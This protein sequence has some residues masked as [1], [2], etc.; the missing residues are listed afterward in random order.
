MDESHKQCSTKIARHSKVL[1]E[2]FHYLVKQKR[3]KPCL[4]YEVRIVIR[5]VVTKKGTQR[6]SGAWATLSFLIWVVFT[7]VC[8][9]CEHLYNIYACV[10]A[11]LLQS[12]STLCDPPMDCSPPGSSVHG[13]LQARILEWI[14]MPFSRGSSQPRNRTSISYVSCTGQAASLQIPPPGKPIT[15]L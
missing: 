4:P 10:H 3:Q 5:E 1:T 8:L 7:V 12:Y 14:A 11:K 2:L 15:Y 9:L 6:A 13:I